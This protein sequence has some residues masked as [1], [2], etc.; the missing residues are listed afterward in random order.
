MI[1]DIVLLKELPTPLR[2]SIE[3][4]IGCISGAIMRDEYISAIESTGFQEVRIVD[5]TSFPIDCLA[6]DP[7][8]KAVIETLNIPFEEVIEVASSVMS[9]KIDGV[10]PN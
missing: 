1:S 9:I 8:A 4:Y 2:N 6:N 3:A 10:K 7:T 5:E